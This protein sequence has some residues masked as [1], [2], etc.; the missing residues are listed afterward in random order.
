MTCEPR[1]ADAKIIMR[2]ETSVATN[3]SWEMRSIQATLN[4]ELGKRAYASLF[5][6][7]CN[8]PA[9]SAARIAGR[10]LEAKTRAMHK[11]PLATKCPECG[12]GSERLAYLPDSE[13]E[14]QDCGYRSYDGVFDVRP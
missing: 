1:T 8:R 3:L 2:K 14:C 9:M 13:T 4:E 5:V 10:A 6:E 7:N 12:A 11:N